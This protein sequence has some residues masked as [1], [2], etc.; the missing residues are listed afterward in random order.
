MIGMI[1]GS[2]ALVVAMIFIFTMVPGNNIFG[3]VS[4]TDVN[5]NKPLEGSIFDNVILNPSAIDVTL[6]AGLG[7]KE[8][9]EITNN[10]DQTIF[11]RCGIYNKDASDKY[12]PQS[13]CQASDMSENNLRFIEIPAGE[14]KTFS[15]KTE[16]KNDY[17]Y[18][19]PEGE[20]YQVT[21][22]KGAYSNQVLIAAGTTSEEQEVK[23]VSLSILVQ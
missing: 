6:Q 15:I 19:T 23:E 8:N 7:S 16:T 13:S 11:F 18:M 3:R 10:N 14:T 12:A 5:Q 21:T 2:V 17:K 9:L 4:M 20:T 1:S 22:T